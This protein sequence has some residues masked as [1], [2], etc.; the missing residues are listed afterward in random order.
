M[1]EPVEYPLLGEPPV[2]EFV[3][4]LYVV[5]DAITDFL[6]TV[7]LARGWFSAVVPAILT[8][9]DRIDEPSRLEFVRLR[10]AIRSVLD[11]TERT[12]LDSPVG[13]LESAVNASPGRLTLV[14]DDQGRLV[15]RTIHDAANPAGAAALLADATITVATTH[16]S[17]R[18]L[19]CD[20]P[21]CNMRFFQQH[22]RRR[23]CNPAC[24]NSDRQTRF[25]QR[26][27]N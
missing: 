12:D 5:P 18:V 25:Q 26:R 11:A 10:D 15:R 4:T 17:G 13:V 14:R 21:A 16:G 23:Y 19:I 22:R 20:R 8:D 2:V 27:K 1:R 9:V 7:D 3:N 6:G 24:A